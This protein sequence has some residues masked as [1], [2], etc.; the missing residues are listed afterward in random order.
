[1]K[2]DTPSKSPSYLIVALIQG[3]IFAIF[4]GI[5]MYVLL[6]KDYGTSWQTAVTTALAAG[7][8]FGSI[9]AMIAALRDKKAKSKD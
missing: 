6:W 4:W 3:I 5:G 1:M 8:L 9:M 7:I 2:D